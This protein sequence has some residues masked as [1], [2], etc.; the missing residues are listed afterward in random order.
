MAKKRVAV[1]GLGDIAAKAY[2]PVLTR[3]EAIDI[4]SVMSR[5]EE[6]V[7]RVMAEYRL[8][9]GGTDLSAVW[10]ASPEAVFIHAPTEAHYGLVLECLRQGLHVYVDKP[11]SYDIGEA[12]RMT[13]AAERY[14]KLLAVGFN[15]RFA[16][17][18]QEAQ[19]WL[20][21]AGGAEYLVAEKHRI[22]Q[23]K[24]SAKQTLY[25]DL[26]HMIDLLIWLGG[27]D[28]QLGGCMLRTD[29][30][31]RL[32]HAGG[33][34]EFTAA[35]GVFAMNRASGTDLERLSLHG[36]GASAEVVNLE[37]AVLASRTG[38]ERN[39]TFSGWDSVLYRRGFV[40]VVEHF[41]A[42]LDQPA[43]C[44]I[45]ADQVLPTHYLIERLLAAGT[46]GR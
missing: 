30:D 42:S 31:G 23:Q 20:Q 7:R 45:R 2:L 10:A 15:R 13:E 43:N 18:Y 25:D 6:T 32:L 36:S 27:N 34:V 12:E 38:G 29:A 1:I 39:L 8:P 24:H 28:N 11:L 44:T 17:F 3:H 21:Q 33:T 37:R 14:G 41:I 26:I 4:V 5:R 9:A 19:A 16:P 22:R 35:S 46:T 40:G